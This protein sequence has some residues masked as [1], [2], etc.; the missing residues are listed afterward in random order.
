MS[1][2]L[3]IYVEL[4]AAMDRCDLLLNDIPVA[5]STGLRPCTDY[6][7]A[8]QLLT[9]AENTLTLVVHPGLPASRARD[10][11]RDWKPLR[12]RVV[13]RV[14]RYPVGVPMGDPSGVLLAAITE[15]DAPDAN[16]VIVRRFASLMAFPPWSWQQA[17]RL[18]ADDTLRAEALRV[19]RRVR[20]ALLDGDPA[21]VVDA[22]SVCMAE[23]AAAVPGRSHDALVSELIAWVRQNPARPTWDMEPIDPARVDLRLCADG[24]LV[25]CLDI[26]GNPLVRST[27]QEH[28]IVIPYPLLLGRHEGRLVSLR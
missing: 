10:P 22:V 21:P 12:S 4:I 8:E 5:R 23:Y 28:G 16:G 19:A 25:E 1:T 20:E 13:A 17:P 6:L 14:T 2:P 9:S 11:R 18:R 24:R 27:P 26:D 7:P 3:L 15:D